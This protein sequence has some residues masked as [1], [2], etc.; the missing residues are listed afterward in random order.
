MIGHKLP[1]LLSKHLC[2]I[3]HKKENTTRIEYFTNN[4]SYGNTSIKAERNSFLAFNLIKEQVELLDPLGIEAIMCADGS[5]INKIEFSYNNSKQKLKKLKDCT[6]DAIYEYLLEKLTNQQDL[7]FCNGLTVDDLLFILTSNPQETKLTTEKIKELFNSAFHDVPRST[8]LLCW[9]FGIEIGKSTNTPRIKKI[10]INSLRKT[11]KREKNYLVKEWSNITKAHP[12]LFGAE[13]QFLLK[14]MD[15]TLK[16]AIDK[17][18]NYPDTL[19]EE[20]LV[21]CLGKL[22]WPRN[23]QPNPFLVFN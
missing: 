15:K 11:I 1:E 8:I 3:R 18:S 2:L 4:T 12:P 5:S 13:L 6:S 22:V 17:V 23:I 9:I 20:E 21:G 7:I 14:Q 10:F 16:E 19:N